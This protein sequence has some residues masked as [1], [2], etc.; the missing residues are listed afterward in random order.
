LSGTLRRSLAT[1]NPL[2]SVNSQ[3][4]THAQNVKRWTNG[5]QVLRWLASASL[6]LED[7]FRRVAGYRDLSKLQAALQP[8]GEPQK[9]TR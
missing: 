4:R 7:R 1:T 5:V 6:F 8:Y 2:E 3:F 9:A